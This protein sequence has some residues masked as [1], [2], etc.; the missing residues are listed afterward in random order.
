MPHETH[1]CLCLL[2]GKGSGLS[3][4][5]GELLSCSKFLLWCSWKVIAA[6]V[7]NRRCVG[8]WREIQGKNRVGEAVA[9]AS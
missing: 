7:L 6:R 9:A 8:G 2:V 3:L 1:G 4:E 5:V